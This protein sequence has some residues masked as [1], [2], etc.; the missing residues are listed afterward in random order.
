LSVTPRRDVEEEIYAQ[1]YGERSKP[2]DP[3][4]RRVIDGD[5][6]LRPARED[7]EP[8]PPRLRALEAL[9]LVAAAGVRSVKEMLSSARAQSL[10]DAARSTRARGRRDGVRST[11]TQGLREMVHSA[12]ARATDELGSL[13][14][15]AGLG[16]LAVGLLVLVTGLSASFLEE[17]H[18][19]AG[20]PPEPAANQPA[21]D[22]AAREAREAREA[23][24]RRARSRRAAAERRREE[25]AAVNSDQA[26]ADDT[27]P[28]TQAPPTDVVCPENIGCTPQSS[29]GQQPTNESEHVEQS[30]RA[31]VD[32]PRAHTGFDINNSGHAGN[33]PDS[34]VDV[35]EVD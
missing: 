15:R 6:R 18:R 17:P 2:R 30:D 8:A 33:A 24:R 26:P 32:R 27:Y 10:R 16:A 28:S 25:R 31:T 35:P 12:R 19:V 9:G 11:R 13:E 20:P 34:D 29:L 22:S 4:S 21:A 5:H 14:R 7:P 23:R 1:L 3:R